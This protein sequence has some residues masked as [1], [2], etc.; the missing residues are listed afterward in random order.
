VTTTSC[1]RSL[2]RP[3]QARLAAATLAGLL[4]GAAIVV[5]PRAHAAD[6]AAQLALGKALFTKDASPAC[7]VCHTLKDAGAAGEVGPNLD[8]L[9]PDPARITKALNNGIGNMPPFKASLSPAQIQ[10]L[11]H[12]VSK[13]SGG[14]K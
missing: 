2:R 11:A 7:A 13:A 5:A 4:L 3:L 8:E 10:A 9:Q 6:D 14:A 1:V 12:Y